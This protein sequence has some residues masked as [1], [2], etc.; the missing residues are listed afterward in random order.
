ME[1]YYFYRIL[2]YI[3]SIYVGW[4]LGCSFF[5]Y[6][7]FR[8]IMLWLCLGVLWLVIIGLILPQWIGIDLEIYESLFS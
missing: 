1:K 7:P 5:V 4:N 2:M 8:R 6:K 3:G